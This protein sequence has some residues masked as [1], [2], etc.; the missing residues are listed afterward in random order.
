VKPIAIIGAAETH[1]VRRSDLPVR[2]LVMEAVRAA[3]ADAGLMPEDIDGIV[4]DDL[5]MPAT[6][7]HEWVASELGC[8]L[9]WSGSLSALGAGSVAAPKIARDALQR[10]AAKYVLC[11]FGVDW[12][13]RPGGP[14]AFHDGY[15]SKVALE[16]PYGF[17]G[18]PLYFSLMANR[19][20]HQY[21]LRDEHLAT[22]AL[23]QRSNSI[24]TGRGQ[25]MRPLTMEDY[26]AAP[27]VSDSLRYPDCCLITDGAAAYLM[28][29][30]ERAIDAPHRPVYV[31]GVGIGVGVLDSTDA[32]TQTPNLAALPAVDIARAEA[33]REAGTSLEDLDFAE[34]YDCF[35]ISCLMQIEDLGFCAKGEGGD[36]VL[37][38]HTALDGSLPVNTHGGL[39]SYSYLLAIEHVIEAVR[40]LRGEAGDVQLDDPELGLITG[41]TAPDYSVLILGR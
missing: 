18:Q 16:K 7:P 1:A 3:I 21:G 9:R 39:L 26:L 36:Y 35:S 30:A 23:N 31:K 25:N 17:N 12:G 20:R 4:T 27:R 6:V 15:P 8:E 2:A 34:I 40:Q 11:Y 5:V 24:R 29:T 19:Y 22:I 28:T 32:I 41:M 14:Y 37:E 13:T 38:G 33:E 10:G